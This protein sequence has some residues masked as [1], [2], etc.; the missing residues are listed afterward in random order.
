MADAARNDVALQLLVAH[1]AVTQG[2]QQQ[3]F[4]TL[5]HTVGAAQLGQRLQH[6]AAQV[7]V[8]RTQLTDGFGERHLRSVGHQRAVEVV[9]SLQSYQFLYLTGVDA[10]VGLDHA[11]DDEQ[12][13]CQALAVDALVLWFHFLCFVILLNRATQR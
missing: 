1:H 4:V 12:Q 6:L 11:G 3:G 9:L 5:Q 13:A 7:H 10:A 2:E 8:E